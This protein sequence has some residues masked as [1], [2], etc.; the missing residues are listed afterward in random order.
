MPQS[1]PSDD[2]VVRRLFWPLI[3]QELE[4]SLKEC[5]EFMLFFHDQPGM[6]GVNST[7]GGPHGA[8]LG[9]GAMRLAIHE[10]H[11]RG[12]AM[13]IPVQLIWEHIDG[14]V[15]IRVHSIWLINWSQDGPGFPS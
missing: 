4:I 2:L 12:E 11:E 1:S 5:Q 8:L 6:Y 15:P 7:F 13:P 3:A 14:L 10:L 9:M